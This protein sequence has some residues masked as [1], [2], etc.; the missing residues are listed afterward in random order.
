MTYSNIHIVT[1]H[2][3]E[4]LLWLTKSSYPVILIDKEGADPSPFT[5]QH[6]IPNKGKETTTYLKYII[7]NY[8]SLP[9]YVAFIHGH[10]TAWHQ[11]YPYPLLDVIAAAN[12]T[13]YDFISL[14]NY[15]RQ[16]RFKDTGHFEGE[17]YN[18]YFETN[19]DRYEFPNERRP[20][21]NYL[22]ECPISAQFIVAKSRILAH[23]KEKYIKWYTLLMNDID[24]GTENK[25][26]TII[27]FEYTWHILFGENWQCLHQKDWF[28]FP[29]TPPVICIAQPKL[30]QSQEWLK[31]FLANRRRR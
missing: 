11:R 23:S 25:L 22:I 10:E 27:F 16:Y 4:D 1:S 2:W 7:E 26:H 14:N 28:I 31:N 3:K 8:H 29:Y 18:I 12:I 19:W 17:D 15:T 30:D 9:D 24:N 13:K 21:F 6:I 20:P 5:P